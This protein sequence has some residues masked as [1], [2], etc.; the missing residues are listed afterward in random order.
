M[1]I[2]I[3]FIN[4]S[5]HNIPDWELPCTPSQLSRGQF[6][7]CQPPTSSMSASSPPRR[8]TASRIFLTSGLAMNKFSPSVNSG[9]SL[10]TMHSSTKI[11]SFHSSVCV[12][13]DSGRFIFQGF[14]VKLF[15]KTHGEGCNLVTAHHQGK[16]YE[17]YSVSFSQSYSDKIFI[18]S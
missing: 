14:V 8:R 5:Q 15:T 3:F 18:V 13:A 2:E 10:G 16:Q 4:K 7:R 1:G 9:A 17:N 11:R 6:W 12:Q